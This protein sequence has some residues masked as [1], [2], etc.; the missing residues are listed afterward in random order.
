MQFNVTGSG[1]VDLR[2]TNLVGFDG[3]TFTTTADTTAQIKVSQIPP[4]LL[5][6]EGSSFRD[7]VQ[8]FMTTASFDFSGLTLNSWTAGLD[9]FVIRDSASNNSITGTSGN[10]WIYVTAGLDTANGGA[11]TDDILYIDY[12]A[13]TQSFSMAGP[14]VITDGVN[15]SVTFSNF[16]RMNVSFGS[17]NDN[18]ATGG[19]ND[20]LDGGS[21]NDTLNSGA[22][23]AIVRGGLGTDQWIADFSGDATAKTINLNLTGL[24]NAGNATSYRDLER[25]SFT[26]GAG[27]DVITSRTNDA[28]DGLSDT[29][30]GGFGNDTLTVG[31]GVDTVNGGNGDDLLIVDYSTDTDASL[32]F[33][34]NFSDSSNTAVSFANIERF[35]F[36]GGTGNDSITL[37][38]GN[39]TFS[40][41]LG[42]DTA[43]GGGG[44]DTLSYAGLATRVVLTVRDLQVATTRGVGSGN[45]T[46]TLFE[47]FIFGEASDLATGNTADEAFYGGV[48]RDRLRGG[49]GNDTLDGGN[50]I[51]RIE[52]G[53][54]QDL[55]SGGAAADNFEFGNLGHMNRL[56]ADADIITDFL[57]N[58]DTIDLSL[59]DA[60]PGGAFDTFAW[61][62]T[63]AFTALGQLRQYDNGTDTFIALNTN[64][65]LA[66]DYT[67]RLNGLH[68][69]AETDFILV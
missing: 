16:E 3:L 1:I 5:V 54:G 61:I 52:G 51:D 44:L 36:R 24:Q 32:T 58:S 13:D 29:L 22:G 25:L 28:N 10:D 64:G 30:N 66:A 65:G 49:A 42:N 7:V 14:S 33:G 4:T 34:T 11:G 12:A 19:G 60:I 9:R 6:Y 56:E 46:A 39:D 43:N 62:G 50:N 18:I 17:G 21:G 26:G 45:D 23:A 8:V 69:L 67:I 27:N 38:V 59:L 31:G 63:A 48:G 2:T 20:T 40:G 35:D 53:S 57:V 37:G 68:T 47:V 15:T 41:G 55:M